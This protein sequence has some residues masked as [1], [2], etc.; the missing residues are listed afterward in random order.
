MKIGVVMEF[1]GQSTSPPLGNVTDT[2]LT[3][4]FAQAGCPALEKEAWGHLVNFR[5]SQHKDCGDG[6]RVR[7]EGLRCGRKE[8]VLHGEDEPP[9]GEA[10]CELGGLVPEEGKLERFE[11]EWCGT[12]RD[13]IAAPGIPRRSVL[14]LFYTLA[15]GPGRRGAACPR[16]GA[17]LHKRMFFV[18]S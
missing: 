15:K 1:L 18:S 9:K 5:N 12:R 10:R 6:G 13:G 16:W 17:R 11:S 14:Q 7:S 3:T 8:E 2:V 4:L